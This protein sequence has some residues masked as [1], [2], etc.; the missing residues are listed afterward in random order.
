LS[1]HNIA[2][3]EWTGTEAWV[4]DASFQGNILR[5]DLDGTYLGLLQVGELTDLARV[6]DEI[7]FTSD[8]SGGFVRRYDTS[9]S[10]IGQ[11]SIRSSGQGIGALVFVPEPGAAA[12][13]GC[14]LAAMGLRRRRGAASFS[15][16][17]RDGR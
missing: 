2:D 5:Y 11:F 6:G 15:P 17:R 4:A 1:G 3:I 9:G 14:G 16:T 8:S 13:L 12:L 10:L 7:W